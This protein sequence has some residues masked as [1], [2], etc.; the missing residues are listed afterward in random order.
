MLLA[1]VGQ[2]NAFSQLAILLWFPLALALS[3]VLSPQTA[4]FVIIVGGALFLPERIIIDL[5]VVDLN[6]DTIAVLSAYITLMLMRPDALRRSPGSRATR[7][8]LVLALLGSVLTVLTNRD[9]LFYG[10]KA[11]PGQSA[12]DVSSAFVWMVLN[13]ILPFFLGS[14]LFRTPDHIKKFLRN[15]VVAG[16]VYMP[17]V[18]LEIRLAPFLHR[19][20]YGF[21]PHHWK[22]M[23]REGGFRAMVFMQHGL[24]VALFL[25]QSAIAAAGL[26]RARATS[27]PVSAKILVWPLL[28]TLALSKS[29][30]SLLYA[31]VALPLLRTPPQF[32]AR[33][34]RWFG[35]LVLTYPLLRLTNVFPTAFL[36][37][38]AAALSAERAAS[39]Q[40]RFDNEDILLGKALERFLF[41][42]GSWGRN[43]VFD[44]DTGEDL[45]TTDGAWVIVLGMG[46]LFK[47][48]VQFGLIVF[49]IFRA[50]K[51]LRT[52]LRGHPEAL[53]IATLSLILAL[54][55]VDMIPNGQFTNLP[56]F[57][58]GALYSVARHNPHI[59]VPYAP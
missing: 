25:S 17:L 13:V 30:A 52:H 21:F 32:V 59:G 7:R 38:Q 46:G 56:F 27:L 20:V 1:L 5:P 4:A 49:P 37:D 57:F 11:I 40:F 6:K 42:W 53:S 43:R 48:L 45:S 22:Q 34:A 2:G 16:L 44:P 31:L 24:A 55:A 47:F 51:A 36:V 14:A 35:Y 15:L 19:T 28:G 10:V 9:P 54:S 39:L 33:V 12:S 26:A 50:H 3:A 29:L 18:L 41:G 23:K 8:L 58:A